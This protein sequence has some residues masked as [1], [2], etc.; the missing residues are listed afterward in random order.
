MYDAE[1]RVIGYTKLASDGKA[2]KVGT[3][4][5]EM[6]NGTKFNV[7][8][9]YMSQIVHKPHLRRLSD[10]DRLHPPPIGSII[11]YRFQELSTGGVPRFPTFWRYIFFLFKSHFF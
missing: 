1:A 11:T 7:G 3:L 10:A 6:A 9:G 5:C 8:S 4:E 2:M